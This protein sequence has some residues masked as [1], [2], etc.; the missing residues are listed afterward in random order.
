L[1]AGEFVFSA[2]CSIIPSFHYF[3]IPRSFYGF[4]IR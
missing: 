1:M 3:I 2:S 4:T